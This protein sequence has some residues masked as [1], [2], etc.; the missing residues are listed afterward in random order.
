MRQTL[1]SFNLVPVVLLIT[2]MKF[3]VLSGQEYY[4]NR[5]YHDEP[6]VIWINAMSFSEGEK[7]AL[8]N[9]NT[10][11][12]FQGSLSVCRIDDQG[13]IL[14]SL[15]IRVDSIFL[16]GQFMDKREDGRLIIIGTYLD[17]RDPEPICPMWIEVDM[18]VAAVNLVGC[19]RKRGLVQ[20]HA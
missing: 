14:D 2:C 20:S 10:I 19:S 16:S 3:T 9:E 8:L 11:T 5:L 17:N 4:L 15:W 1:S 18:E 13:N 12:N 6:K 7:F